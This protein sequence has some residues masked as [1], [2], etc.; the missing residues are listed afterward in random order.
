MRSCAALMPAAGL[1]LRGY[2]SSRCAAGYLV[3]PAA[4]FVCATR[5]SCVPTPTPF[6]WGA[7]A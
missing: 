2:A 4:G 7:Q 1:T 5:T 6:A 3:M